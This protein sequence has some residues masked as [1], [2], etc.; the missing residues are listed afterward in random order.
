M[1]EES[2]LKNRF[3]RRTNWSFDI[4]RVTETVNQLRLQ[5][6]TILDLTCSNPTQCGFSYPKNMLSPL[7][8][9]ENL[10]YAP[11]P[12]GLPRARQAVSD[13]YRRRGF[14]VAPERIFLT[15]SSS[16]A[17]SALFRLLTDPGDHVLFPRPSYP[18]FQFLGALNDIVL[19]TY[20]IYYDTQWRIDFKALSA[21]VTARTKAIVL[22]NP[23]NPTGSFVGHE[24]LMQIKALC[25]EKGLA[26]ISDEVFWDFAFDETAVHESL[27]S[28]QRGLTFVLGGLSK[29]LGLPQMK[30]SWMVLSG[31]EPL[32]AQAAA[33]LEMISDTYLS[34][35]TPVQNALESWL[36][37]DVPMRNMI[38]NRVRANYNFLKEAVAH[39]EEV[40]VLHVEGGWYAMLRLP[41][42]LSEEEA[43]LSVLREAQVL[44]HPGYFFDCAEAPYWVVSLLPP[45][46]LFKTGVERILKHPCW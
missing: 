24:S 30:L 9:L 31:D 11:D 20:P 13:Y 6:N 40:T 38:L 1:S 28:H 10:S 14:D 42:G 12:Q 4:N 18:L 45:E 39:V 32:V 29:A 16:E 37:C 43:V 36:N 8:A 44:V 33:R 3:A 5:G 22:V 34:V 23:N 26:I 25:L 21:W 46:A 19:D 27:V 7:S 2:V 41:D 17:Y 35:N 15:A